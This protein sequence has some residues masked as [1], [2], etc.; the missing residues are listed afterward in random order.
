VTDP[1]GTFDPIWET[2]IYSEGHHLNRYP[3]DF[4]VSFVFRHAPARPRNS[5]SILEVGCGVGNNLWFAAREG[6]SV[7]GIDG[8]SSAIAHARR[9]FADEG[10]EADL[11]VGDFGSLPFADESVDLAIDRGALTCA[12]FTAASQ[13]IAE[14]RRVLK[15]GGSF[16]FNPYSTRHTSCVSHLRSAD[17]VVAEVKTHEQ[18]GV[19]QLCFYDETDVRRVLGEGW[20]IL[21]LEHGELRNHFSGDVVATWQVTCRRT[22]G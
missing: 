15:P 12:S 2:A 17:G 18:I 11:R 21:A 20:E 13:A 4:V 22:H 3:Y 14:I 7:C 8:S 1:S 9:R 6:F 10:L 5:V 16:M 19:G